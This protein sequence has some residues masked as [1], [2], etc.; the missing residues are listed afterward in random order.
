[1]TK[2]KVGQMDRILLPFLEARE[3]PPAE[4]L[5]AELLSN[6]V[7]PLVKTIVRATLG[8]SH[9]D[10]IHPD[11]TELQDIDDVA[12]DAYLRILDRLRRLKASPDNSAITDLRSYVAVTAFNA[13]N[14]YLRKKHPKRARL[15]T[16]LRY[17]LTRYP[18]FAL[19]EE[20][21]GRYLCG[22]AQWRR[23]REAGSAGRVVRRNLDPRMFASTTAEI[24]YELILEVFKCAGGPMFLEDFVNLIAEV[25]QITDTPSG[26][27]NERGLPR[28]SY[29]TADPFDLPATMDEREYLR[30]LWNEMRQLPLRQ[31]LALMLALKDIRRESM[32]T[33]LSEL[34]IASYGEIASAV[35]LSA[36]DF[37]TILSCLPLN[38]REI[39]KRL[40]ITRQQV[41]SARFSARRR[42]FRRLKP[43]FKKN[44]TRRSQ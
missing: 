25:K 34:G 26:R 7:E 40:G 9:A 1:V 11:A 35:G 37:E 8:R 20:P 2:K 33:L 22:L 43:M 23:T 32:L 28:L 3:G 21:E 36:D 12:G 44:P 24:T 18:E 30:R 19:W 38:D 27:Y 15:K 5:F 10:E 4:R 13:C 42:L 41:I 17:L 14:A 39:S 6:C 31:R 16:H 29:L